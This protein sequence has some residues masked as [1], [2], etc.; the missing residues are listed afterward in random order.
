MEEVK[1]D[2]K[3]I[4]PDDRFANNT[5]VWSGVESMALDENAIE[6]S[7]GK[8]KNSPSKKQNKPTAPAPTPTNTP[9]RKPTKSDS[10]KA[11]EDFHKRQVSWIVK[12]PE[13]VPESKCLKPTAVWSKI[14]LINHSKFLVKY[15][16]SS[17]TKDGH[18]LFLHFS[19]DTNDEFVETQAT[20]ICQALGFP[21]TVMQRAVRTSKIMLT[22]IPCHNPEN[23]DVLIT[24]EQLCA[25]L[26]T[27]DFFKD[28]IYT[29]GPKWVT[30]DMENKEVATAFIQFLS[31][32][33]F[34]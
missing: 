23:L 27:H 10:Q 29:Q 2:P 12:H 24:N 14:Q 20:H 11:R 33:L 28:L 1:A 30:P 7:L 22:R 16:Q 6:L 15:Q 9:P 4:S 5:F 13:P 3:Y 26:S 19:P 17:W 18:I 34:P 21:D 8:G 25:E 32:P 31:G